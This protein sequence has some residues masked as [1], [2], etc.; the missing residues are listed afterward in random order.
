MQQALPHQVW[1]PFQLRLLSVLVYLNRLRTC[2]SSLGLGLPTH[3]ALAVG[4]VSP[5]AL[6]D[7]D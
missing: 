5:A 4:V 1:F 6:E 3:A 7:V 2:E